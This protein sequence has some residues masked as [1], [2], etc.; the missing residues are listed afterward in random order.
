MLR[1]NHFRQGHF[2]A[3]HFGQIGIIAKIFVLL[4]APLRKLAPVFSFLKVKPVTEVK[5][6]N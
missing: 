2:R 1:S 6:G 4:A 3:K 5:R